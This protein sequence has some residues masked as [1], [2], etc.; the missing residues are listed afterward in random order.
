MF[1]AYECS[2][3]TYVNLLIERFKY[4][5]S[6]VNDLGHPGTP[7]CTANQDNFDLVSRVFD[8]DR[9]LTDRQL[10]DTLGISKII[11]IVL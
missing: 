3:K 7:M 10:E 8:E 9:R 6:T 4:G 5:W 11:C 2:S 1:M